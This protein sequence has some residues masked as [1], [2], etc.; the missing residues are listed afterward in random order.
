MAH[1]TANVAVS[2]TKCKGTEYFR[3][4][5][6]FDGELCCSILKK[7]KSRNWAWI[8]SRNRRYHRA[9]MWCGG[10]QLPI[11]F[12]NLTVHLQAAIDGYVTYY[13][14]Y[15]ADCGEE[16]GFLVS[17]VSGRTVAN[18]HRERIII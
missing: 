11:D 14:S 2:G 6:F 18:S 1:D 8:K 3:S 7:L 13:I 10:I 4:C 16:F 15:N 5:Q 17:E 9:Y 12:L